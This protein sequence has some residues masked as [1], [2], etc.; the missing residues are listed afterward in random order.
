M[1]IMFSVVIPA[2][3]CA[4]VIEDAINSVCKQSVKEYIGEIIVINDGSTD[5]TLNVLEQ[6][7][8]KFEIPIVILNQQNSAVSK[9]R[10]EGVKKANYDWIAFLDSDDEW[11]DDKIERQVD[12]IK[13]IGIDNIDALGGSFMND[14][15]KILFKTYIGLFKVNI[16]Q[17]CF[18]NFPQP[19]T[20]VMKKSVFDEIGGFSI[21][22]KYAEDGN[23]F[24]KVCDRYNLYY[25]TKQVL[26]F[27]HGKRGFGVE[28]LSGNLKEMHRGNMNNIAEL[29]SEKKIGYIFYS[30]LRLFYFAKYIRRILISK[31]S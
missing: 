20:V 2:Y 5:D 17:I 1:C 7:K 8:S 16:K 13:K 19:S 3:N 29:Y 4:D 21:S 24:L 6:C 10:N 14:K 30:F 31:V 12:I 27:G 26:L 15:L 28:G 9:A 22:Q 25:D 23:F 18:K 11:F